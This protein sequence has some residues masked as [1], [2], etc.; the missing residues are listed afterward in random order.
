M[1]VADGIGGTKEV[2]SL[3]TTVLENGDVNVRYVQSLDLNDNSYGTNVVNWPTTHSFASLAGSDKAEFR[4]TNGAGMVVMDFGIDYITPTASIPSGHKSLGTTGGDGFIVVGSIADIVYFDTSLSKNFNSI[5]L[6]VVNGVASNGVNLTMNSPQTVSSTSY[7]VIDPFF[8]N[9][10]FSNIYEVTVRGAAF[11]DSGFGSVTIPLV[12]NSPPKTGF[13]EVMPQPC[14]E[15]PDTTPPSIL[16]PADVTILA[17]EDTSPTNTGTATA[18]D[19]SGV[20]PSISYSDDVNVGNGATLIIRTWTAVDGSLNQNS[21]VQLITVVTNPFQLVPSLSQQVRDMGL[22]AGTTQAL[23]AKLA[24]ALSGLQS[25]N[26]HAAENQLNA[27]VRYLEAQRGKKLTNGQA[28]ALLAA[29]SVLLDLLDEDPSSLGA[30]RNAVFA[31]L[32]AAVPP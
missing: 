13:N 2:G 21:A 10:E 7:A 15:T 25:G 22:G 11:G 16:P 4:F 29:A 8:A 30:A 3:V 31:Q 32:G 9:W 6:G 12:H 18:T 14:S 26:V 20:D 27:F 19:N 24:A 1:C 23:D 5:G 28:D 17:W